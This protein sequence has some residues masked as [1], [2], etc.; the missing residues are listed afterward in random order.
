MQTQTASAIKRAI[1]Y[2]GGHRALGRLLEVDH[3]L[4]GYWMKSSIPAHRAVQ[5]EKVTNGKVKRHE[6]RPD[7]YE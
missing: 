3:Q 2:A 6:L 5:L 4:I 1:D 7:L